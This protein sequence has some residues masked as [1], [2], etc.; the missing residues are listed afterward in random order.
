MIDN[1]TPQ[2]KNPID[3]MPID[4]TFTVSQVN[5]ILHTLAYLP[6]HQVAVVMKMIQDQAIPQAQK[7]E[8]ALQNFT[9]V[10]EKA[11]SVEEV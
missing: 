10:I 5:E 6:F 3:D 8:E 4:L 9:D 2:Q 11:K 7:H 1:Q